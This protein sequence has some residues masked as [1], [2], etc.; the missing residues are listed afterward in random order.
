MIY[1]IKPTLEHTSS[2]TTC[3]IGELAANAPGP[4]LLGGEPFTGTG[5]AEAGLV[6]RLR[7]GVVAA[8]GAFAARPTS[9]AKQTIAQNYH[10]NNNRRTR[11]ATCKPTC[12][13]VLIRSGANT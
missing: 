9:F 10:D 2:R 13:E 5:D 8:T 1:I 7:D 12:L 4:A 11:N 3:V 6:E